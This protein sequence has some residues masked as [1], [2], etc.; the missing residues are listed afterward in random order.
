MQLG[1]IK[2]VS[3]SIQSVFKQLSSQGFRLTIV[4][5]GIINALFY[6]S[7]PL[8]AASILT[9]LKNQG[10]HPN[11]S[12]LYREIDFLKKQALVDELVLAE[13]CK[14]YEWN[15]GHHHHLI[16]RRCNK[17]EEVSLHQLEHFFSVIQNDLQRDTSFRE[18]DHTLAFFGLCSDC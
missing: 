15:R 3:M 12:T 10:V 14:S 17:I 11:K 2:L 5:K 16:C 13:G 7:G 6:S 18:V 8:S 9:T 1:C 4:R